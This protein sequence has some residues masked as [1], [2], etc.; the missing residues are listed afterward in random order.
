MYPTR[1]LIL[2]VLK[3]SN[4]HYHGYRKIVQRYSWD[5]GSPVSL[6][7]KDLGF[8][9]SKVKQL[10]RNYIN[11]EEL[12]RVKTILSRRGHDSA[13]TSVAISMRGA[14][15]DSRSQGWCMLSTVISR[16]SGSDTEF[17]DVHYRS[18][19]FVLK[20][21]ADL[22]FLPSVLERV[23]VD[24]SRPIRFH[25]VNGF[26]S[27]V[28]LATLLVH[29]KDPVEFLQLHCKLDPKHFY[30]STRFLYRSSKQSNQRFPYSPENMQHKFLWSGVMTKR[31]IKDIFDFLHQ[32][33]VEKGIT[34]LPPIHELGD[35]E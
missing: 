7:Y 26:F 8:S 22:I 32:S 5:L 25:F 6:G 4:A 16:F 15:K 12:D 17:V 13:A 20:F 11:Q 3:D 23:G 19:E 33:Y 34:K 10:E 18:T 2:Q 1:P 31:K 14:K 9:P 28:F 27:G 30:T 35:D 21:G 29:E 24:P